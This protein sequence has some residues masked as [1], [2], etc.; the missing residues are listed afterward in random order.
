MRRNG[1]VGKLDDLNL[2]PIMS[3]LVILVPML[4]YAF[5]YNELAVQEVSLPKTG[6]AS[7]SQGPKKLNITVLVS[8]E[9][10]RIKLQGETE[11][12]TL[13]EDQV[14]PKKMYSLCEES[15]QYLRYD[16]LELYQRIIKLKDQKDLGLEDTINIGAKD[17]IPWR[18]LARTIDSVRNRKLKDA[19]PTYCEYAK[20]DF[21]RVDKKDAEGK[22]LRLPMEVFPKIVFI[23]L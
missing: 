3:V 9:G 18:V 8:D 23:V 15:D 10:F 20:S 22:P 6:G 16:Y 1:G 4:V 19:F 12:G 5:N 11:S 13:P 21:A 17:N 7:A 14:I 2:I